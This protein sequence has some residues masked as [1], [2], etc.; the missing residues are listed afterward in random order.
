MQFNFAIAAAILAYTA[1]A[2]PGADSCV[3]QFSVCKAQAGT[4][5]ARNL[6]CDNNR[7]QCINQCNVDSAGAEL[8]ACTGLSK[9]DST[10]PQTAI[11]RDL[12]CDVEVSCSKKWADC[13]ATAGTDVNLNAKC[14]TD[15]ADCFKVCNASCAGAQLSACTGV[16]KDLSG[17]PQTAVARAVPAESCVK[18]FSVCK[19]QAGT[20]GERNN[21]CDVD[22]AQCINECNVNSAGAE[23]TACTGLSKED[24]TKPQS[25]VL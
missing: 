24:S 20:D 22:R 5:G 13:K 12:T 25:A 3:K 2:A 8:T 1:A 6:A 15:R 4:D 7:A 16:R 14:T 18:K 19:A 10:K 17:E 9:E 23:L 11:A 21:K